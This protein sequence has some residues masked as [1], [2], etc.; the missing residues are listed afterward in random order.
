MKEK[1]HEKQMQSLEEAMEE[2]SKLRFSPTNDL[3]SIPESIQSSF[4]GKIFGGGK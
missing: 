4:K 2:F 3:G 1:D